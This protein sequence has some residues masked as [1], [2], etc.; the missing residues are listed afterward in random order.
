MAYSRRIRF[1]DGRSGL[2][3]VEFAREFETRLA[4]RDPGRGAPTR[5]VSE[6]S[7]EQDVAQARVD[8]NEVGQVPPLPE[9]ADE[10]ER[11]RR[12]ML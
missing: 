12:P 7:V 11:R 1:G 8:L 3:R 2:P 5:P 6:P 9:E 10:G 4:R